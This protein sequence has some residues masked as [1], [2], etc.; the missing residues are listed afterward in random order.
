MNKKQ[1]CVYYES[2]QNTRLSI[3]AAT[4]VFD[5]NGTVIGIVTG[6]FRLDIED[7]VDHIKRL[8]NVECTVFVDEERI[9]TTV[10]KPGT[11]ERA[12]GTK[13]DNPDIR[14][15]VIGKKESHIGE[16]QVV[17]HPMKVFYTPIVN[18]GEDHVV[19]MF[20]VGIPTE[21]QA[22]LIRQNAL[23][24]FAITLAGLLVF[25]FVLIWN[26]RKIVSPIRKLTKAA[27]EFA[28]GNLDV[29]VDVQTNDETAILA[30]AFRQL[31]ESLKSKT[32]VALAIAGGDL[33][34]WVPLRSERDKLG[35]SL[36]RMRYG[37]YDSI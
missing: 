19:G 16:A 17:G 33:R 25:G 37:L 23:E 20:F 30:T 4:P 10:R 5:E 26:V 7:W 27:I 32:E 8:H 13:L 31:E 22:A 21:R 3:R 14:N 29:E 34:V 28:D 1:T 24:S 2:T 35:L 12:V 15:K 6:G 9:M 36:I 11:N 18:E